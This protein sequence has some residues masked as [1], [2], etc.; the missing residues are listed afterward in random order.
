MKRMWS[1]W[2]RTLAK[3]HQD[4]QGATMVEY[5]LIVAAVALPLLGVALY[6]G[7]EIMAWVNETWTS[8]RDNQITPPGNGG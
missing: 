7:K 6:Y 4:E 1:E 3:I 5:I 2:T 8:A